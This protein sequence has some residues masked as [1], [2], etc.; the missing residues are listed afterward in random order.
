MTFEIGE[1]VRWTTEYNDGI[2]KDGGLGIVIHSTEYSYEKNKYT[3]YGIY[4]N[5]KGD[6]VQLSQNN[7]HKLKL[8]EK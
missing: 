7:V 6:A 3:M 4:R 1:L 2:V 8:K 5:K